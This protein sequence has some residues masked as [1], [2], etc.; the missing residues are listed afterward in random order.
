M[1]NILL[2]D[3]HS[4]VRN[5]IKLL[6]ETSPNFKIIAEATTVKE[7]VNLLKEFV[8]AVIVLCEVDYITSNNFSFFNEINELNRQI[9]V[10]ILTTQSSDKYVLHAFERQIDG[11]LLKSISTAELFFAL[12]FINNGATYLCA[13]ITSNILKILLDKQACYDLGQLSSPLTTREMEVLK[14]ISN[15]LTNCE[16]S[17][18]L[19]ISKRTVEGHRQNL[20]EKTKVKNTAS[21]VR[22][23]V[24]NGLV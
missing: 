12:N 15:G 13:E 19:F 14:H 8:G 21:L 7:T 4:V 18:L 9:K 22:F 6:L 20:I 23:A 3:D 10:V 17:E 16:I 1:V 2:L 5:G 24:Q 11:Y